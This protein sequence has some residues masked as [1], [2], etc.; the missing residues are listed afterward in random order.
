MKTSNTRTAITA[1]LVIT[2]LLTMS[3]PKANA[4]VQ[5]VALKSDTQVKS[6]ARLYDT[7]I[8][9]IGRIETMALV[10][11]EDFTRAKSIIHKQ[12]PNL[13]FIRSKLLAVALNDTTLISDARTRTSTTK[14]AEEFA[15]DLATNAEVAFKLR[16][17][18]AVKDKISRTYSDGVNLLVR[19][20]E[21][22]KKAASEFKG[23]HAVIRSLP[24]PPVVQRGEVITVLATIVVASLIVSA[25]MIA[26]PPLG[27]A[28]YLLSAA[29][30]GTVFTAGYVVVSF[31]L[32]FGAKEFLRRAAAQ[33]GL[34]VGDSSG[35]DNCL[36]AA[37]TRRATCETEDPIAKAIGAC[38]AEY[39]IRVAACL[40]LS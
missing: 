5:R 36:A 7:A 29:A 17:G 9:E 32:I 1:A 39:L 27:L 4:A 40:V 21:K 22:L 24:H 6:E 35:L 2:S 13:K 20:S 3:L 23:H 12:A 15:H 18:A 31:A 25:V 14:L 34:D 19:V 11:A 10:T 26:C 38:L 37:E 16:G 28:L 33:A 30:L 8:L